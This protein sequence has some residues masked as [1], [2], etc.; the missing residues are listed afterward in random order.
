MADRGMPPKQNS[1]NSEIL[2][3]PA[4]MA[5]SRS[6][7]GRFSPSIDRLDNPTR[8]NTAWRAAASGLRNFCITNK[9]AHHEGEPFYPEK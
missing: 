5:S 1:E 3:K 2:S 6:Y 9:K 7:Q 4:T 8:K